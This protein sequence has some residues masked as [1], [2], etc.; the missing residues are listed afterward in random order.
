MAF[1][2]PQYSN[3]F[4][5]IKSGLMLP[6]QLKNQ[7]L[8]NALNE[9]K[10]MAEEHRSK[11]YGTLAQS[12]ADLA[13]LAPEEKKQIMAE[14]AQEMQYKPRR[15]ESEIAHQGAQTGKL[16]KET[17]WFDRIAQDEHEYKKALTGHYG[18]EAQKTAMIMNMMKGSG[19]GEVNKPEAGEYAGTPVNEEIM[20]N[21]GVQMP[22]PTQ[23]DMQNKFLLGN[24]TYGL[25]VKDAMQQKQLQEKKY[26]GKINDVN[27]QITSTRNF[28]DLNTKYN[29]YMD[30]AWQTGPLGGRT[31]AMGSD[32]QQAQQTI[33]DM[34]TAA[35]EEMRQAM[36]T[37]QFAVAD[38]QAALRRK[39]SRTWGPELRKSYTEGREA[40]ENRL[41]QQRQFYMIAKEKKI[42]SD[43]ADS[44][45]QLYQNQYKIYDD[46]GSKVIKREGNE[47]K[48]YL[49]PEA[50]TSIRMTGD[51]KPNK[52]FSVPTD[53]LLK[54]VT[55]K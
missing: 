30:N 16:N 25:K 12:E 19:Q 39:P 10:R 15:W 13:R 11:N 36:G 2:I 4:E 38:L 6:G 47:W 52:A 49:S 31:P 24:D 17:Q 43:L 40:I 34:S 23:Q 50:L 5:T 35:V 7:D 33:E 22:K 51:Y 26:E 41:D 37:G 20:G 27:K 29:Y 54:I 28:N 32:A 14:R 1:T 44:A 3:P 53:E 46:K 42:P 8:T 21:Y 55:G 18:A 45:W 48:Q 9:Y